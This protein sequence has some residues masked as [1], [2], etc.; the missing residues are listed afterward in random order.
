MEPG[1]RVRVDWEFDVI[2]AG[3]TGRAS[4]GKSLS[5]STMVRRSRRPRTRCTRW[6]GEA[7][8][9]CTGGTP[10]DDSNGPLTLTKDAL[11]EA[12]PR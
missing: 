10:A 7:R 2:E 1:D 6:T 12:S 5:D 3:V 11:D 4:M 9:D 8:T